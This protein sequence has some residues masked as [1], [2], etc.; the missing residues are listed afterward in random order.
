MQKSRMKVDFSEYLSVGLPFSFIRLHVRRLGKAVIDC[1]QLKLT[2][3]NRSGETPISALMK[4]AW[5]VC[6][7]GCMRQEEPHHAGLKPGHL[8]SVPAG[9][10]TIPVGFF[11]CFVHSGVLHEIRVMIT[12]YLG[13]EQ[14][15]DS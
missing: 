4:R 8:W 11:G 5:Q 14:D 2:E 3:R 9:R 1:S 10:C 15:C 13:L 12:E 6:N 7:L